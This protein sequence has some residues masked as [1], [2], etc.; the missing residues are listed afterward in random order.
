[1][2]LEVTQ[3][4]EAVPEAIRAAQAVPGAAQPP[5]AVRV[6][7]LPVVVVPQATRAAGVDREVTLAVEVGLEA[8]PAVGVLAIPVAR[9][10][11][12]GTAVAHFPQMTILESTRLQPLH[13]GLLILRA[14]AGVIITTIGMV[15]ISIIAMGVSI[16]RKENSLKR[17]C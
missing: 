17:L 16:P 6:V 5:E 8:I 1:M 12:E 4:A 13:Q 3:A 10:G 9:A 14:I 15:I 7:I 2:V 11:L